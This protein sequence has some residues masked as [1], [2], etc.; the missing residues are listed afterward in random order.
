MRAERAMNEREISRYGWRDGLVGHDRRGK[1]EHRSRRRGR[2]P[3]WM[4]DTTG[5]QALWAGDRT[6]HD[7]SEWREGKLWRFFFLCVCYTTSFSYCCFACAETAGAS[8]VNM[9]KLRRIINSKWRA[10]QVAIL[11]AF[12][13]TIILVLQCLECIADGSLFKVRLP[14]L[15]YLYIYICHCLNSTP[16][17]PLLI[18]LVPSLLY[19]T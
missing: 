19:Q 18:L 13:T 5:A 6:R 1:E 17:G 12:H 4:R 11:H 9:V 3:R 14:V 15:L 2:I 8:L 16:S 10:H 7:G